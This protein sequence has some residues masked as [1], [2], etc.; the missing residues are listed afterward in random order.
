MPE[1]R[2]GQKTTHHLLKSKIH[3]RILPLLQGLKVS[4]HSSD[5]SNSAGWFWI[6]LNSLLLT[7]SYFLLMSTIGSHWSMNKVCLLVSRNLFNKNSGEKRE[8]FAKSA[9]NYAKKTFKKITVQLLFQG[10]SPR[11]SQLHL[12]HLRSYHPVQKYPPPCDWEVHPHLHL[13]NSQWQ[14][15]YCWSQCYCWQCW[16]ANPIWTAPKWSHQHA[17]LQNPP[18]HTTPKSMHIPLCSAERLNSWS[19]FLL[20]IFSLFIK[21][22]NLTP[23]R[24]T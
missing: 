9:M 15:Q 11:W 6:S 24:L 23:T 17:P 18:T 12:F 22:S 19:F 14:S 3:F 7:A 8:L 2:R 5:S 16:F 21:F 1:I 20:T 10:N 13:A 4:K